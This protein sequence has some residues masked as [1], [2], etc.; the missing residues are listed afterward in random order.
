MCKNTDSCVS[1]YEPNGIPVVL[2]SV[3]LTY[4]EKLEMPKSFNWR[5][6]KV[7]ELSMCLSLQRYNVKTGMPH[8]NKS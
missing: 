6:P 3:L 4:E 5:L 1:G 7:F 8:P 2:T